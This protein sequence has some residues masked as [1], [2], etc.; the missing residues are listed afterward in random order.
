M[1]ALGG[2]FKVE[3]QT[4]QEWLVAI[5]IGAGSMAVAVIVKFFSRA[6]GRRRN[7]KLACSEGTR[8]IEAF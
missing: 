2:I 6:L 8:A 4:W 3:G 1:E 5:G 7:D